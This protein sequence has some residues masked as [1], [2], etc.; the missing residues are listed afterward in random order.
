MQ[1]SILLMLGLLLGIYST[2]QN[3][4][5]LSGYN[6]T[7]NSPTNLFRN[8]NYI[9]VHFLNDSIFVFTIIE[10]YNPSENGQ[11]NTETKDLRLSG[12]SFFG[13]AR[14]VN[15][16]GVKCWIGV[17]DFSAGYME[18]DNPSYLNLKGRVDFDI[19]LKNIDN[20]HGFVYDNS[21]LEYNVYQ[22]FFE[23]NKIIMKGLRG[24]TRFFEIGDYTKIDN[25]KM[26]FAR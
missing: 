18:P 9:R 24:V 4:D 26:L 1:K 23:K 21:S 15:Y 14:L 6:G 16:K 8:N 22:F 2:A 12:H 19:I 20:P 7:Y 17:S 3:T 13:I 25:S 5:T 10:A 11:I